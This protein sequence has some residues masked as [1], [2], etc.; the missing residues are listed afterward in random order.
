MHTFLV[1][2]ENYESGS[3]RFAKDHFNFSGYKVAGDEYSIMG[4]KIGIM[5]VSLKAKGV[6][7]GVGYIVVVGV[8]PPLV[9]LLLD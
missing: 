1:H 6:E 2:N 7:D 8:S 3:K 4:G 9:V 5:C